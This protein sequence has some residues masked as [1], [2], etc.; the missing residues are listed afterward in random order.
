MKR[1]VSAILSLVMVVCLLPGCAHQ[2]P[3]STKNN[4]ATNNV[5]TKQVAL[6]TE[7]YKEF[8]SIEYSI[9]DYEL[10]DFSVGSATAYY[11][12]AN[13]LISCG[14]ISS[15]ELNNVTLSIEVTINDVAWKTDTPISLSLTIPINGHA[16]KTTA[17]ENTCG[18][19]TLAS[20]VSAPENINI[21]V[22]EVTGTITLNQ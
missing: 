15:G 20:L 3:E 22:T 4:D 13:L 12:N 16:E 1:I 6:T 11:A 18:A 14:Q 7:N 5:S 9:K 19:V 10:K 17:I 2:S 21:K 8:F